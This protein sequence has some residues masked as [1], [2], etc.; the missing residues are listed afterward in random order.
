MFMVE[1]VTPCSVAPVACPLPQGDGS[2]PKVDVD[3]V[4]VAPPLA[5]ASS[6]PV[7]VSEKSRRAAPTALAPV[8]LAM[9]EPPIALR[10]FLAWPPQNPDPVSACCG[11]IPIRHPKFPARRIR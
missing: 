10:G 1:F 3:A 6:T 5:G 9:A 4:D 2:V 7:A 11:T 8:I